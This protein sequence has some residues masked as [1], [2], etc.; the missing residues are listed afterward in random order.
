MHSSLVRPFPDSREAQFCLFMAGLRGIKFISPFF[1]KIVVS[2]I[3]LYSCVLLCY[4]SRQRAMV[5]GN[6][7]SVLFITPSPHK[8]FPQIFPPS[9]ILCNYVFSRLYHTQNSWFVGCL[10]A[11]RAVI[12]SRGVLHSWLPTS[13]F[14]V[15]GFQACAA[16][17]APM[18]QF[19]WLSS[20]P[21]KMSSKHFVLSHSADTERTEIFNHFTQTGHQ[22]LKHPV[23]WTS[24]Y[25]SSQVFHDVSRIC[26][27]NKPTWLTLFLDMPKESSAQ[28]TTLVAELLPAKLWALVKT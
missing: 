8:A 17:S 10:F 6:E 27:S 1:P 7:L 28:E 26:S 9:G 19:I 18:S 24:H 14:R 15:S 23:P 12:K 13:A 11:R 16:H 22:I 21:I 3:V 4:G 2:Q 5:V 20:D 25:T